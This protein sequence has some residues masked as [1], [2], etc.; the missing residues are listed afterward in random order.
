MLVGGIRL[1]T[2]LLCLP[3]PQRLSDIKRNQNK[4]VWSL[5]HKTLLLS[6]PA[7]LICQMI[8]LE[9]KHDRAKEN[10]GIEFQTFNI[11]YN[12]RN[13]IMLRSFKMF[14]LASLPH[15]HIC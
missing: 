4:S 14:P 2:S 13:D 11:S 7:S 10:S 9:E 6:K 1:F 8:P 12:I 3:H 15:Y 5:S